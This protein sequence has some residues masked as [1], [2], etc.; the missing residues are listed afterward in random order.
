MPN[1]VNWSGRV[2]GKLTVLREIGKDKFGSITWECQC[3][4][5]SVCVKTSNHLKAGAKS[6]S[7]ACGV[8]DSNKAR[9]IHGMVGT[10]EYDS[11]VSMKQ[12]CL[13]PN[14]K[15]YKDWGGRG[16][17]IHPEW[18]DSFE[19]FYSHVGP[20]PTPKHT[21]DRIDNDGNY[22]P[23]NVKWSTPKE[24][25]ERRRTPVRSK[26]EFRKKAE[27]A[28]VKYS[29]ARNRRRW[30]WPEDTWFSKTDFRSEFK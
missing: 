20:K 25:A 10:P 8:G 5:G 28:G 12:R 2:Q 1:K 27:A 24:Q 29:T 11:W 6:C 21:I 16:I 18:I 15:R 7:I 17:K 23:G 9:T 19:A 14:E 4:C 13:N 30:G 22:E 26:S 3:E